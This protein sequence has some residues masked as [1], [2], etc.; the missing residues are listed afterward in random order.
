MQLGA[1]ETVGTQLP[2]D[3][4]MAFTGVVE[5]RQLSVYRKENFV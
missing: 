2:A 1:E 5:E 3:Q 4:G